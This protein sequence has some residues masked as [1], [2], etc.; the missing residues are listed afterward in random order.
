MEEN[1]FIKIA[2]RRSINPINAAGSVGKKMTAESFVNGAA[3]GIKA[4]H[5]NFTKATD[6][7]SQGTG[8]SSNGQKLRNMI[9]SGYNKV[10][11]DRIDLKAKTDH[12]LTN[13]DVFS[14]NIVNTSK[15][16]GN[17]YRGL[18]GRDTRTQMQNAILGSPNNQQYEDNP[19]N[20]QGKPGARSSGGGG[21]W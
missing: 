11:G 1:V 10:I 8:Q 20:P 2:K 6:F 15:V 14:K 18:T 21:T 9:N 17:A 12:Q 5:S 19:N 7:M 16:L 4:L 13:G 3:D